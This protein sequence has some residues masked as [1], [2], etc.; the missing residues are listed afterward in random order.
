MK[1]VIMDDNPTEAA[2]LE[3]EL[4]RVMSDVSIVKHHDFLT[5]FERVFCEQPDALVLD[6]RGPNFE[7]SG[8]GVLDQIWEK[9][10][11]P[12]VV[13][14]AL[15]FTPPNP[16]EFIRVCTKGSAES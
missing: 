1:I 2:S 4:L 13:F 16:S 10:F 8:G 6:I 15:D 7:T 11:C 3:A 12:V 9:H 14:S 5:A